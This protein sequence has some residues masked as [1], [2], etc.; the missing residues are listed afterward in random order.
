MNRMRQKLVLFVA[1][2]LV[3]IALGAADIQTDLNGFRLMQFKTAV[4]AFFG[5]PFESFKT[6]STIVEAYRVDSDAYMV[7]EYLNSLPDNIYSIQLTGQTSKAFPFRELMLGD[8]AKKD[9][10]SVV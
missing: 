10:K 4:E 3:P 8:D 9:R 1:I 7:F 6:K 5:K 2:L